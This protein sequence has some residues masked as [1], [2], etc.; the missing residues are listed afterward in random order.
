MISNG[1]IV[2][3]CNFILNGRLYEA[4][5]E[6]P[7]ASGSGGA[8]SKSLSLSLDGSNVN[9]SSSMSTYEESSGRFHRRWGHKTKDVNRMK[10]K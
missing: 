3:D 4:S 1:N 9:R 7:S 6:D 10:T 2:F 5:I 8:G